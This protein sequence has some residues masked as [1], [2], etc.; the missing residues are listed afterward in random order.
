M[1][2]KVR[3][4]RVYV[5]RMRWFRFAWES[6]RGPYGTR[7][8]MIDVGPLAVMIDNTPPVTVGERGVW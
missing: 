8:I 3:G 4:Y 5:Q 7:C 6:I 2:L 1:R